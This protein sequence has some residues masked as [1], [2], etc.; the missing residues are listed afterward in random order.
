VDQ[1]IEI[2]RKARSSAVVSLRDVAKILGSLAWA[3]QAI[4]FAQG[5][6]WAIQRLFIAESARAKRNLSSKIQ[7]NEESPVELDWWSSNVRGSNG[8]PMS[9]R[10][11]DLVIFSDASLSGWAPP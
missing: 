7:L 3:I 4:P 1:I 2:C 6:Y 8:R 10:D 11:P 5:H 9:V